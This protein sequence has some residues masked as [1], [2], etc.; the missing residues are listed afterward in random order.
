MRLCEGWHCWAYDRLPDLFR[1]LPRASRVQ[2]GLGFLGPAGSWWLRDR[3]EGRVPLL[4]GH[5]L[6]SAVTVGDRVRV[7]L[8]G[9]RGVVVEEVD[10]VI[11]GT[12]FRLDLARLGYIDPALRSALR[13]VAGAP[14]LDRNLESSVP[15]LF[16]TGALAAPS[17]GPLMRFVAGTHFTAP[18]LARRLHTPSRR[19]YPVGAAAP[20]PS[21][22]PALARAAA[23]R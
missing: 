11:A 4:T 14:I 12:G 19:S 1:L 8:H 2:R 18:R 13:V 10:H 9:P 3:I 16:F 5:R 20:T 23:R 7:H 21:S 15:G 17:L 22:G 6:L